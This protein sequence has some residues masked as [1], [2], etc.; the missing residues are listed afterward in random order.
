MKTLLN[1]TQEPGGDKMKNGIVKYVLKK[2]V[3]L[4]ESG[5]SK[6]TNSLKKI[7]RQFANA[8]IEKITVSEFEI[9]GKK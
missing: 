7:I 5:Q 4:E 2:T 1:N 9:V 3:D 8:E 6:V